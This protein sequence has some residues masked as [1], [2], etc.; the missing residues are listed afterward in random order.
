MVAKN[1]YLAPADS[2]LS[3]AAGRWLLSILGLLYLGFSYYHFTTRGETLDSGLFLL[4][5]LSFNCR[6]FGALCQGNR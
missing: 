4:A 2:V 3:P 6:A 5:G 1:I